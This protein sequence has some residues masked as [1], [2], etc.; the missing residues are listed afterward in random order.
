MENPEE[1][2]RTQREEDGTYRIRHN[3]EL[4]DQQKDMITSMRERQLAFCGH[5]QIV[6][7]TSADSPTESSL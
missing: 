1:D 4:Y 6:R 2:T 5:L 7:L 3:K